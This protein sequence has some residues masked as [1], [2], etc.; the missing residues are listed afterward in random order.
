M[1]AAASLHPR[2]PDVRFVLAGGPPP[3]EEERERDLRADVAHRGLEDVV[4]VWGFVPEPG[5]AFARA[6]VVVVPSTWPE[7]FG[8]VALEAMR[9]GCAVV[10]SAH[11]GLP[12]IVVAGET[13]LLAPPG[14]AVALTA[15]LE[16]LLADPATTAAMGAAGRRRL[17]AEFSVQAYSAALEALYRSLDA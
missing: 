15:A 3:G 11:G 10:G 4:E 6:A 9:A 8:M 13:G 1:E 17:E 14:D 16:R 7:P 12:E 2:Y 5:P